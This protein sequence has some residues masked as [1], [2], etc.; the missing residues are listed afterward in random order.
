MNIF[1]ATSTVKSVG[2]SYP[3]SDNAK[4]FGFYDTG[5]WTVC[6]STD[7]G[8]PAPLSGHADKVDAVKAAESL[9]FPW[10]PLYLRY[11]A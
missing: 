8:I 6:T 9:P 11:S 1:Q 4:R 3:T 10:C 5:C 7:N 2:W